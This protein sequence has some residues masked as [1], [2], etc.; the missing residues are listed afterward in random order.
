[1]SVRSFQGLILVFLKKRDP[2]TNKNEVFYKSDIKKVLST[3][4]GIAY[5]IFSASM[6]VGNI[7]LGLKNNSDDKKHS[8]VTWEDFLTT[9]FR[10]RVDTYLSTGSTLYDSDRA[11]EFYFKLK[12]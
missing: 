2:S 3:I 4:N 9:N 8:N 1:M 5:Q 12:K 7:Y 11:V 6:K 10:L